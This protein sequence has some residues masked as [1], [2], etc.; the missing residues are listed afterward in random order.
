MLAAQ[1]LTKAQ[2]ISLN[3]KQQRFAEAVRMLNTL[4]PLK[5]LDRGYALVT[6]LDTNI[7]ITNSKQITIGDR[8]NT[9]LATGEFI[10]SVEKV[11]T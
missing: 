9:K 10:C 4:S 5:T 2:K 8:L 7:P 3:Q 11:L 1:G 6:S